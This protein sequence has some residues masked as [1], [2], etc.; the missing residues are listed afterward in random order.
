[1]NLKNWQ[2]VAF[3]TLMCSIDTVVP[4]KIVNPERYPKLFSVIFGESIIK[5]TV[6]V[7]LYDTLVAVYNKYSSQGADLEW[8][9]QSSGYLV[10][11]FLEVFV[12][13]ILI[14]I[15]VGIITT[16]IFK[17]A[18]FLLAEKGVAEVGLILITG[19]TAYIIS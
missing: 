1:M 14:G 12:C 4:E 3:A 2:I 11:I 18:R 15:V 7:T 5:D 17:H 19:Y 10:L 8:T 16:V 9:A 13:S 6:T